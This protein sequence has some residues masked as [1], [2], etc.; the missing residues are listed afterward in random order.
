MPKHENP[1]VS[2]PAQGAQLLLAD[3]GQKDWLLSRIEPKNIKDLIE[4]LLAYLELGQKG[5]DFV[6]ELLE[7]YPKKVMG[8]ITKSFADERQTPRQQ[9]FRVL[10]TLLDVETVFITVLPF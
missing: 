9:L 3:P 10:S 5:F 7:K 6:A 8:I 4:V 2:T 1:L